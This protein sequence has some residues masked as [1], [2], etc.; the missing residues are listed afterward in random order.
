ML[1]LV[2]VKGIR[3]SDKASQAL[4]SVGL[5]RKFNAVLVEDNEINRKK[6][7]NVKD[8]VMFGIASDKIVEKFKGKKFLRLHPPVKGFKIS[9]KKPFPR[10]VIGFN[11]K[12]SEIIERML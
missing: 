11:K 6:A 8:Y 2:R 5:K 10:G 4:D 9:V 12:A 1:V 3:I 7:L